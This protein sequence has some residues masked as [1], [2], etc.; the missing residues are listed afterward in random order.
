MPGKLLN[1]RH[2]RHVEPYLSAWGLSLPRA[3]EKT[4]TSWVYTVVY[5]KSPAV[6]KVLTPLGMKFEA[7]SSRILQC[8]GGNGAVRL[9]K[10]DEEALLLEYIDGVKLAALVTDGHDLQA[11]NVICDVIDQ[12][13]QYS[14][15]IPFEVYDLRRHFQSLFLRAK[16]EKSDSIYFKAAIVAEQLLASEQNQKLLHGDIHHSNILKSSVRGWLAIDPQSLYGESIYDVANSFFNPD[17]T[18]EIVETPNRIE[19]LAE[20]F[21]A[22]LQTDVKRVLQFAYAHGGLSSSWQLDDGKDPQRRLRI[23]NLIGGLL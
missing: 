9:L 17:D 11:A 13:H 12:L 22:R 18:P 8:F 3:I 2:C 21:A 23:T 5:K 10:F 14:G 16:N 7:S 4:K 6:L 20:L 1:T 15:A 19:A